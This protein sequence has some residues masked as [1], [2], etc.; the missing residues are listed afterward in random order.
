L[1][2]NHVVS[3][4]SSLSVTTYLDFFFLSTEPK[5]EPPKKELKK[6]KNKMEMKF[7]LFYFPNSVRRTRLAPILARVSSAR[8]PAVFDGQ[9]ETIDLL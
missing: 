1:S 5:L 6:K 9:L 7:R 3:F 4:F 2:I 8:V